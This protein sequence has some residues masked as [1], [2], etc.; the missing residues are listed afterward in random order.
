M[1]SWVETFLH[2]GLG[3][4][5]LLGMAIFF[6]SIALGGLIAPFVELTPQARR[7]RDQMTGGR[8]RAERRAERDDGAQ[9]SSLRTSPSELLRRLGQIFRISNRLHDGRTAA[10]LMQAGLRGRSAVLRYLNFRLVSPVALLG[11]G[12]LLA[13]TSFPQL[14]PLYQKIA[15]VVGFAV[16]GYYLPPLLLKN[17]IDKRKKE[18]ERA[19]PD[20][21]DLLLIC[22][23][24]GM[25]IEHAFKR[26]AHE[27]AGTSIELAKEMSLAN[28]ELNYLQ[29]RRH[30]YENFVDRVDLDAVKNVM[31][32][33]IQSER[34]GTSLG[35]SLRV[36]AQESRDMRMAAAEKKAA[37][38]P[39][40]L[41][42]PMILFFLPVLFAVIIT[43]AVLQ[44]TAQ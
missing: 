17:R 14:A 21:V 8:R 9:A 37:A 3:L 1:P 28:A 38:L 20:S 43:P 39:P 31:G 4:P 22:V 44:A 5:V 32:C 29:E 19:W 16:F 24:T 41:T 34:Y 18:I 12:I 42:V 33:L 13:V 36:L 25:S 35:A 15:C 27:M 7:L 23:E 40:K 2:G 11:V 26:I 30:A 10:K 6:A